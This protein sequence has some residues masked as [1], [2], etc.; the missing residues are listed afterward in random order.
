[1]LSVR[2]ELF[3][4]SLAVLPLEWLVGAKAPFSFPFFSFWSSFLPPALFLRQTQSRTILK[5]P[6]L[7]GDWGADEVEHCKHGVRQTLSQ[8]ITCIYG[9]SWCIKCTF[10]YYPCY[11]L[12]LWLRPDY[13]TLKLSVWSLMH[14]HIEGNNG[15]S[16]QMEQSE[17]L[18]INTCN[19]QLQLF[20]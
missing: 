16:M 15:D 5:R 12:I 18:I 1:M 13:T 7:E 20:I 17:C 6:Q 8:H 11:L 4:A 14:Q 19:R 10:P 3:E 2:I 9:A